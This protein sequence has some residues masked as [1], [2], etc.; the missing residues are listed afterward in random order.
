MCHLGGHPLMGIAQIAWVLD[1]EHETKG[2]TRLVL[3]ALADRAN[4][5]GEC[6]PSVAD[7]SRRSN[8]NTKTVR[9]CIRDLVEMG[10]LE[11]ELQAAPDSRISPGHRPNLY[12]LLIHRG[13]AGG[14]PVGPPPTLGWGG[15][16]RPGGGVLS[17]PQ[18]TKEPPTVVNGSVQLTGVNPPEPV[19]SSD[20]GWGADE[21]VPDRLAEMRSSIGKTGGARR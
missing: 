19:D 8:A 3:I 21:T 5:S 11:V 16:L 9:K 18:T 7:L 2:A 17:T 20:S 12:R 13:G 4:E 14:V 15:S 10:L 6:Y 1:Q